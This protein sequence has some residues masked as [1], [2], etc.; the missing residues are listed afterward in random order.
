MPTVRPFRALRYAIEPLD[1]LVAPPYDV[2][3]EEQRR[4]YLARSPYNVVHLTLPDSEEEAAR[5]L[6]SWRES[7][8]LREDDERYWWVAQDY[9]GPDGVARTR[10][11]FA[12]SVPVT[13]Y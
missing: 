7:G 1:E 8:V 9:T 12:A 6:A 2:I 5:D 4:E 10:E 11:G 3:S 13:P